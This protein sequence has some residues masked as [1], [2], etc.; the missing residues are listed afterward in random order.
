VRLRTNVAKPARVRENA[1][2]LVFKIVERL[3]R[4]WWVPYGGAMVMTL[5][6]AAERFVDRVLP[7]A[8]TERGGEA[9]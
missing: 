4:H 2:Y 1:L 3:A 8:A 6:L 7:Q 5:V 9:A